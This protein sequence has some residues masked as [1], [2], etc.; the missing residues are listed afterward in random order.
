MPPLPRG[1]LRRSLK[2]TLAYDGTAYVGWQRQAAGTSVQQ[3]VETALAEVEGRRVCVHG[4]G[5]TDAGVHALGQVASCDLDHPIPA[6]DLRRALNAKLPRDVRIVSVEEAWPGFHARFDAVEKTYEYRIRVAPGG[7]PFLGRYAWQL[8]PPLDVGA[9]RQALGAVVGEHDFAAFQAAG[10][11]AASSVRTLR[12]VVVE[13]GP[14]PPDGME[15]DPAAQRVVVRFTANGFL[16]HM[17]RNLVGTL[18][19]IGNGRRAA[20]DLGRVLAARDR[21]LAGPT[22]PPQGLFLVTVRYRPDP[23]VG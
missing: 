18:V 6:A 3:L 7:T 9:M 23:G 17:V 16:R 12:E 14:W 2:L 8:R 20:D 1:D 10:S 5:R 13:A 11:R 19:E 15:V 4:S 22:A 21:A